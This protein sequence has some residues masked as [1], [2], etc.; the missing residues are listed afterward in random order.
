MREIESEREREVWREG[1]WERVVERL[2][3]SERERAKREKGLGVT[4]K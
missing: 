4:E 1:Y 2:N 3:D